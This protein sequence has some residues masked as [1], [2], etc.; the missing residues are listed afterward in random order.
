[1][2]ILR[3][4]RKIPNDQEEISAMRTMRAVLFRCS[5]FWL[6]LFCAIAG[7]LHAATLAEVISK[8]QSLKPQE[9]LNF[10]MNGARG[11]GEFVFYGTLPINEFTPLGKLFNSRYRFLTLQH[12][13]SPREGILNR[14]LTESRAGRYAFD[15]VQVDVS[16]GYQLLNEGWVQPYVHPA[17]GRFYP[18][19]YDPNGT[20]HTMY[21]LTTALMYNTKLV[22]SAQAPQTYDDLLNAG[23]KGKML[24]D[25]EAGY[26]LAAMEQAWGREKAVDY[27]TRLSKQDLSYRRGGT[28]TTQIVSSGEYPIGIAING[29]TSAAVRET[30]APLAFKVLSPKIVK[31]EGLFLAKNS[32][33]PHATLLFADWVLSEEAQTFLATTLGKGVAMKGV[34]GKFPEFQIQPD[35]VVSPSLGPKLPGYIQD[36]AKIMGVR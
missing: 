30:G 6:I 8:T 23:W 7:V 35:Y 1:M 11:E 20:W 26:I 3:L 28:L 34:R 33:H 29:E 36:F 27:L 4:L 2:S 22:K 13:F 9:R 17:T 14:A 31:P 18:G 24:F 10:L 32:P 21:Y 25:P 16:Y 19:T 15:I 12:Y 5:V